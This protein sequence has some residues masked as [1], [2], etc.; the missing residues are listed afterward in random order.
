MLDY[1]ETVS[2]NMSLENV[3]AIAA[4]SIVANISCSNSDITINTATAIFGDIAGNSTVELESAFE[5]TASNDIEDGTPVVFDLEFIGDNGT[6]EG[7]MTI[8]AHA[9][10]FEIVSFSLN[11]EAGNNNGRLDPGETVIFSLDIA[12]TGS[13]LSPALNNVLTSNSDF[14]TINNGIQSH[15]ALAPEED[16]ELSFEISV[17]ASAQIGDIAHFMMD[18][19]AG[20]YGIYMSYYFTV[21]LQVEDWESAGF[22]QYEW[23]TSGD[24]PW[25]ITTSDPYEGDNCVESGD[26]A[27]NQS[28]EM[29][30]DIDVLNNDSI[31]F[32]YKVSSESSYDFLRFLI[33]ENEM[34]KWSGEEVW[35]RKAYAIT[36]GAHS[37]SWNYTKD[38]STVSGDDKAWVDYI[39]F[40]AMGLVN[41]VSQMGQELSI[42]FY[43]NPVMETAYLQFENIEEQVI[44]IQLIDPLG[45]A[46]Q[47][48]S[49]LYSIGEQQI[50]LSL[51][52][53][54]SGAYTLVLTSKNKVSTIQFIKL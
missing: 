16:M 49:E 12:N 51:N 45:K 19:E 54:A 39:V 11:D 2:L 6:W 4:E 9:P 52:D 41:N 17:S 38:G 33:D 44:S 36:A 40:P 14:I 20:E 15:D 1:G 43:P 5:I 25:S 18:V 34:D 7:Q 37:F 27:N 26:I 8:I 13:S 23:E 31:S 53:L 24:A 30:I 35:T 3:G 28:S 32:Y 22:D 47:I 42:D 29:T 10:A 50:E 21:G 48:S 46:S